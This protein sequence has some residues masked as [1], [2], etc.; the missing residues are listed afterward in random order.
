MA[1][2]LTALD[3]SFLHLEDDAAHMHVA[4]VMLFDGEPPAYDEFVEHIE[5]RLHL[6]PRY[7]QRL[8][9]VPFQQGRP[10][11]VWASNSS[12]SPTAPRL[13][14]NQGITSSWALTPGSVE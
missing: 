12:T 9:Q 6:V 3:T 1:D 2:R 13:L 4:S 7:R 10:V 8:A 5:R 11:W 14:S